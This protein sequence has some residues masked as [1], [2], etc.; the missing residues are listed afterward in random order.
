MR[1]LD[2]PNTVVGRSERALCHAVTS[3]M[4]AQHPNT[5]EEIVSVLR[6]L[7][8]EVEVIPFAH[9][10]ERTFG[11]LERLRFNGK[12]CIAKYAGEESSEMFEVTALGVQQERDGLVLA[13]GMATPLVAELRVGERVV[14]VFRE[15]SEGESLS[16]SIK[17]A[18]VGAAE[19]R[20]LVIELVQKL[21]AGGLWLWDCNPQNIWRRPDGTIMLLEG[22]CVVP[23]EDSPDQLRAVNMQQVDRMFPEP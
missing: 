15:F 1:E 5:F 9:S 11:H 20:A 21:T 13:Q 23:S 2:P 22:Q 3:I 7:G 19:A 10:G 8:H 17:G 16:D 18:R 14:A 6:K 4:F 12:E